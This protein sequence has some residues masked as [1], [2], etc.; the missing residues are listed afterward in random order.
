LRVAVSENAYADDVTTGRKPK[1]VEL[2]RQEGT[3]RA[4]RHGKPSPASDLVKPKPPAGL[5]REA[6]A[7]RR[8]LVCELER[9]G[10][11]HSA[12]RH[13]IELA[14]VAVGRMRQARALIAKE[15]L[16]ARGDRGSVVHPAVRVELSAMRE[17]RALLSELGLSPT[18]RSR[19]GVANQD[20]RDIFERAGVVPH[21]RLRGIAG[22]PNR[23]VS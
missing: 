13:L 16:T 9:V 11:L 17:L 21:R 10:T 6:L 20:L 14:A 7:V 18:S 4:D 19:L 1:P 23:D 8:E 22:G 15:G 2:H 3:Y 12:D 5:F